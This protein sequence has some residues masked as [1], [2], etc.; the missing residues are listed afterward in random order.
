MRLLQENAAVLTAELIEEIVP[1][2]N[3]R[4]QM[5]EMG[6][7]VEMIDDALRQTAN[8]MND[9]VE[10]LLKLQAD[11]SYEE[12]LANLVTSNS[13]CSSNEAGPSTSQ[14][15]KDHDKEIEVKHF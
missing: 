12:K 2:A 5:V 13:A 7:H 6:F 9:A 1:N 15:H 8:I 14:K 11:G 10:M 3:L 4:K